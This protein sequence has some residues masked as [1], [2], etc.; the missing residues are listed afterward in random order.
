MKPTAIINGVPLT[1][2]Q[3]KDGLRQIEQNRS[4]SFG[5]GEKVNIPYRGYGRVLHPLA[6][7]ILRAKW[8]YPKDYIAVV[9][10]AD[11]YPYFVP[12]QDVI[13]A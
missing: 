6:V 8:A 9:N 10:D 3:L 7:E 2:T 12:P 13:R 11:G 1:E 4:I 5:A